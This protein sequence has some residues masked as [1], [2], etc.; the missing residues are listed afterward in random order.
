VEHAGL[1][2][3][4]AVTFTFPVYPVDVPFRATLVWSDYPALPN[5]AVA[6]VNDLDLEVVMPGGETLLPNRLDRPD[7]ANNVERVEGTIGEAGIARVVITGH[8]VPQGRQPFALFVTFNRLPVADAG[9]DR[10][11][12]VGRLVLLDGSGSFDPDGDE[13]LA[14]GWEQVGGPEI[15]L[16]DST[17]VSPVFTAPATPSMITFTLTVTD[18]RGLP[19]LEDQVVVTVRTIHYLPVVR[20][21]F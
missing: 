10:R 8:N 14:Y 4:E 15:F 2:T 6:L 5:A 20:C 7:R 21:G 17:M 13:P 1:E 3:G 16:G 18:T 11:V 19:S 9:A 12:G